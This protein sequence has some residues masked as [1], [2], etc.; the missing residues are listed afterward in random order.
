MPEPGPVMANLLGI[1][2]VAAFLFFVVQGL[3]NRPGPRW[4]AIIGMP[5]FALQVAYDW[6]WIKAGC[7][8]IPNVVGLFTCVGAVELMLLH[9]AVQPRIHL[10]DRHLWPA[11][12]RRV[13]PAFFWTPVAWSF[14][15][16]LSV[17][18][19]RQNWPLF[20]AVLR[21]I[22]CVALILFPLA[23]AVGIRAA[24]KRQRKPSF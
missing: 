19:L 10:Q 13:V 14:V 24:T 11:V 5:A 15:N 17:F 20:D 9:H 12:Y 7:Y 22:S 16:W 2:C 21:C 3:R 8:S 1:L 6:G 18:T 23:L 4:F